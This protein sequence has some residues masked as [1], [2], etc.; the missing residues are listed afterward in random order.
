MRV[1]VSFAALQPCA[2]TP[3]NMRLQM[4][5]LLRAMGLTGGSSHLTS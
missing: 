2:E 4:T 5:E 3:I 1:L